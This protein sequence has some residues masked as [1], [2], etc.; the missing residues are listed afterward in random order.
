MRKLLNKPWFVAVMAVAALAFV[1]RSAFSGGTRFGLGGA[2]EVAVAGNEVEQSPD[3]ASHVNPFAVVRNLQ[4]PGPMR[5]PFAF[6][7]KEDPTIEKVAVP[8]AVDSLH[9]SAVWLQDGHTLVLIND[10]VC[11]NGDEIGRVKIDAVTREG[12]W[13]SHWKG[14]D[15]V[16]VGGNFTLNTPAGKTQ[17]V[18]SSL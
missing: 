14:R 11:Q 7:I 2:A 12:V 9:L 15:F 6:R 1:A 18:A 3:E 13:L 4:L 5:D 16:R 10:R 17:R 8:D